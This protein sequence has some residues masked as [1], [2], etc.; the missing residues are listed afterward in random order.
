MKSFLI[1]FALGVWWMIVLIV[2]ATPVLGIIYLAVQY[3]SLWYFLLSIPAGGWVWAVGK[4][5]G[6]LHYELS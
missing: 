2:V 5:A 4:L 1:D 3:N 6:R